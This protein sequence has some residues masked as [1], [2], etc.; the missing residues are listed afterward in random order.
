MLEWCFTIFSCFLPVHLSPSLHLSF[1][2]LSL[3]PSSSSSS[4][5][6]LCVCVCICVFRGQLLGV[7]YTMWSR[8][9]TEVKLLHQGPLLT[10]PSSQPAFFLVR[11]PH[12]LFLLNVYGC[13]AC[14]YLCATFGSPVSVEAKEYARSAWSRIIDDC[15]LSCGSWELNPDPLK[16]HLTT[17]PS[18]QPYTLYFLI[19]RPYCFD[20]FHSIVSFH[21]SDAQVP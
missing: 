21:Q 12:P 13:F 9:W 20:G 6:S 8:N 2:P 18:L 14:M 11:G 7:I 3:P 1:P 5:L 10:E 4:S 17:E 19:Q 16:V 15:E